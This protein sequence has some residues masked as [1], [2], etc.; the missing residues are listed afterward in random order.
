VTAHAADTAIQ[1]GHRCVTSDLTIPEH[2]DR[3]AATKRDRVVFIFN[4]F[5][6]LRRVASPGK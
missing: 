2:L 1:Q 5:D 4:F 6:E 3:V